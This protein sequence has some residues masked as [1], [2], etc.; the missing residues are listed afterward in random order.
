VCSLEEFFF[1]FIFPSKLTFDLEVTPQAVGI[2]QTFTINGRVFYDATPAG[3]AQ[4]EIHWHNIKNPYVFDVNISLIFY[5]CFDCE[6]FPRL[7]ICIAY[8]MAY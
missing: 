4:I 8:V 5:L 3:G 7:N 6:L 1:L 2:G